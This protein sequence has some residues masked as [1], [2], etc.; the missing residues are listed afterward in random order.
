MPADEIEVKVKVVLSPKQLA[1]A[2]C[3]LN[4]HE[5]IVFFSEIKTI[6]DGE[7]T[8]PAALVMQAQAIASECKPE[9]ASYLNTTR[10]Q[11]E[12]EEVI[13]ALAE[14]FNAEYIERTR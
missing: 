11:I 7:W 10:R 5:Q 4:S 1:R 9:N 13:K 14:P 3:G 8:G 2:W 12:A 6:S